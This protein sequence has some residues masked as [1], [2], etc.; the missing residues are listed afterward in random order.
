MS[1][2]KYILLFIILVIISCSKN[3]I[4]NDNSLINYKKEVVDISLDVSDIQT[5]NLLTAEN[6]TSIIEILADS[7]LD[8]ANYISMNLIGLD[9][10]NMSVSY[11]F[12]NINVFIR[13][14][15]G[16]SSSSV[17]SNSFFK[18]Y[19]NSIMAVD[20]SML[21]K[22]PLNSFIPITISNNTLVLKADDSI[23]NSLRYR[24]NSNNKLGILKL[25]LEF[26][27]NSD[28]KLS[29]NIDIY[30]LVK[31]VIENSSSSQEV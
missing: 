24:L 2:V 19:S 1:R 28:T 25:V 5:A 27:D 3:S 8:T 17:R 4:S 12:N 30:I 26:I 15:S 13:D 22:I 21:R 14:I 23:V 11:D 9:M 20:L 7:V 18:E 31:R 29:K 16:L 6:T 10:S